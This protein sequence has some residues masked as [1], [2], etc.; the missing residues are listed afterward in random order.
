VAIDC[1]HPRP[2]LDLPGYVPRRMA[3]QVPGNIPG[4]PIEAARA[5][6][7]ALQGVYNELSRQGQTRNV[8]PLVEDLFL[9]PGSVAVGV[10]D[11]Q[12][13][14]LL[15]PG[16]TGFTAPVS[17]VLSDVVDP[18]TVLYPDGTSVELGEP[19]SYDFAPAGEDAY[20]TV[21]GS[22]SGSVTTGMLADDSVT[23]A[24]LAE[25]GANTIKV[26]ATAATANP[27]D[28]TIPTFSILGRRGS[29]IETISTTEFVAT[30]RRVFLKTGAT[31][32][33][34]SPLGFGTISIGDLPIMNDGQIYMNTSGVSGSAPSFKDGS[35]LAGSGGGLTWTGTPTYALSI[36]T[37]GVTDAMLRQSAGTSVIGRSASTTG[38]VADITA[39]A[40]DTLL[41]R[42]SG[43]LGFTTLTVGMIPAGIIPLSKLAGIGANTVIGNDTASTTNPT[44]ISIGTNSVLG[45]VAGNIVAATLVTAQIT[46]ANVTDAKISNRTALSVF[47]RSANSSGVGADISAVAAAGGVL[48]ESGSAIGF[49]TIATA[50]ITDAAVTNAKLANMASPRLKGRTTA[51]TGVPEDLTLTNSTSVTWNTATGGAISVERA[52]L[53]GE[54][55][56]SANA[57]ATTITRTTNFAWTGT[58]SFGSQFILGSQQNESGTLPLANTLLDTTNRLYIL[59]AGDGNITSI[60]PS[61]GTNTIGRVV[62]VYIVGSGTKTVKHNAAPGIG[63]ILCPENAD[64]TITNRGSFTLVGDGATNGWLAFHTPSLPT[65]SVTLAKMAN[66]A[67]GTVIGRQIDASTGV[68]VALTG[69]EQGENFRVNTRQTVS[70][71]GTLDI[72]LNDDTTILVLQLTADATLRS[73][74]NTATGDG[75]YIRVEHDTGAFTLT[76]G[77]NLATPTYF[78]L[79]NPNAADMQMQRGGTLTIRA[80]S[81]FWRPEYPGAQMR[82]RKNSTGTVFNRGR[83]NLIEGTGLTFTLADD[84]TNDEVDTTLA[85]TANGVA[86]ASLRQ[87]AALSV[88]GRSANST[89]NVADISAV[90]ASGS[91]LRESGSTIGWGT[92]ATAGITDA[93]VTL[94]K[95]ADLAQSRII[96]RAEGAGTGVPTALTATQ[97]ASIIDQENITWTGTASF[98]GA[99]VT[100]NTSGA[101][102]I[103]SNFTT[104]T[105]TGATVVSAGSGTLTLA[106]STT[107]D[108]NSPH[109]SNSSLHLVGIISSTETGPV[110][111]KAIGSVGVWRLTASA[112]PVLLRGMVAGGAGHFVWVFNLDT[113]NS[114]Q[115]QPEDT[116][117]TAANRFSLSGTSFSIGPLRGFP[118]WYDGTSSR[119]RPAALY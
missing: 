26:N 116:S 69:A 89:G 76:L 96:G 62:E 35:S 20:E 2:R 43:A 81:G 86:D 10:G 49:G 66:L 85:L 39:S 88:I 82:V 59:I 83:L 61:G 55:T 58:H 56:A 108:L 33:P 25:M 118:F 7:Q 52:A 84:T 78:P 67:A 22:T 5:I 19:G 60:T 102:S 36:T 70:A 54:V 38:N 53:T 75:R 63:N 27:T 57:N 77:H 99:S 87:S 114:I 105:S 46:D 103:T 47:G 9:Q 100:V 6:Q 111:N 94:A 50:G 64:F 41:G 12:T 16:A 17:V 119:W 101:T 29:N 80:R 34:G 90:A 48:R 107:I 40:D 98:T 45:R 68:P 30:G 13:I 14:T 97:V 79:F 11:G 37:N 24:K 95:M 42:V 18:V 112:S 106:A 115:V 93:A 21:P 32:T 117:S 74:S 71:S 15:P 1:D 3:W 73:L 51:S 23:N 109:R 8:I 92:I 28:L 104:L 65:A 4:L 72:V 31:G 91:V 110:D 44:T 113:T